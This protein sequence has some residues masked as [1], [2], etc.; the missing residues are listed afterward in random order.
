MNK[1]RRLR[2]REARKLI[3]RA[4]GIVSA[5]SKDEWACL[6]AMPTRVQIGDRGQQVEM[7]AED[8]YDAARLW[9]RWGGPLPRRPREPA[10]SGTA[11]PSDG[12]GPNPHVPAPAALCGC[13]GT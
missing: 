8:L 12:Q 7:A 11:V 13:A 5:C 9:M 1:E 4:R 3:E 6:N 10:H 2:L